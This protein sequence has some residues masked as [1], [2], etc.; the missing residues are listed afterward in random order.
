MYG[1]NRIL[2]S[3]VF[4]LKSAI[5][6]PLQEMA[7]ARF[8]H[9]MLVFRLP[10]LNAGWKGFASAGKRTRAVCVTGEH[11]STEPVQKIGNPSISNS[12]ITFR[13]LGIE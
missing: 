13:L 11:S 6:N 1:H 10:W 2:S 9:Y 3:W 4:C 8:S 12:Y 5:F 7:S